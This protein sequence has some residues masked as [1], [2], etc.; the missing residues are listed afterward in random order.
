[1]TRLVRLTTADTATGFAGRTIVIAAAVLIAVVVVAAFDLPRPFSL[2]VPISA[3]TILLVA[4]LWRP[5]EA[6]LV[7]A[8]VV[9]FYDTLSRD[10]GGSVKQL[11]EVATALI[12]LVAF[13]RSVPR[14]RAWLWWPRE[15]AVAMV[16]VAALG[17][18]VAANV[19][20]AVWVPELMLV[21][22][23]IAFLY[24]VIWT[25]VRR[26]EIAAAMR[27]VLGVGAVVMAL[28]IIELVFP[29]A[30]QRVFELPI[31]PPR[32]P[33][34]T[35]KAVF[36]H[37]AL[38]GWFTAFVALFLFAMYVETRRRRWLALAFLFSLGPMLSARRKAIASIFIGVCAAFAHALS[39]RPSRADLARTWA[40][41]GIGL[42]VII[43]AFIPLLGSLY[44]R[45]MDRYIPTSSSVPVPRA[46]VAGDEPDDNDP[47]P[48]ARVALYEGAVKIALDKLP[49]GAG[50]GRYASWMSRV[51]YSPLY[52]EYGLSTIPG[53][54]PTN[55]RYATDTFWPQIL[56]E[57][58]IIGL[59][60]YVGFLASLGWM[61][62]TAARQDDSALM[63][64]FWLGTGMV[65][66]QAITE[67]FAN[68]M[69]HSPPRVYLLF[70]AVGAVASMQWRRTSETSGSR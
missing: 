6:L 33:L 40:P 62:W 17:S 7:L 63:R 46:P 21:G 61:L 30:F 48:Q 49:L 53:L 44:S 68:A 57:F 12:V 13:V 23:P 37:P 55:S 16:F 52:E 14:I 64:A 5:I 28:G 69:F 45:T 36:V 32:G 19:P 4:Y 2:L 34:P 29:A 8:L 43:L 20:L 39:F 15:I 56:G 47:S 3:G 10:I 31:F 59:I 67:S 11:D 35:V 66:A 60:G 54:R 42:A 26:W 9:L 22:K 51:D 38:F 18:T 27:V 41:V 1:M 70:L 50:L 58:G 65:F 25:P 24:A